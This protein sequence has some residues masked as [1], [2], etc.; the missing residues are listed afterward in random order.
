MELWWY[1][2]TSDCPKPAKQDVK[3]KG[4]R[5]DEEDY[6][7]QNH[8]PENFLNK[9]ENEGCSNSFELESMPSSSDLIKHDEEL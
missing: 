7:F 9:Y 2:I 4:K 6:V 3:K 5:Y 8:L 1:C